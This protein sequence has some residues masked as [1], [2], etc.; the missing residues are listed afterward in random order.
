MPAAARSANE[1]AWASLG[2]RI[3]PMPPTSS[4]GHLIPS[5]DLHKKCNFQVGIENACQRKLEVKFVFEFESACLRP[6]K[7][8]DQ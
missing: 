5:S 6:E 3:N 8:L 1:G 4:S 2:E 7:K